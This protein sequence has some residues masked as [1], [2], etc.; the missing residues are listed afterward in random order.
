MGMIL[1]VEVGANKGSKRKLTIFRSRRK[2]DGL[3]LLFDE[4][5][6]V[7]T[8]PRPVLR[9]RSGIIR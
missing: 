1:R 2:L 5:P 9:V 4:Q 6:I 7:R 8:E 3:T